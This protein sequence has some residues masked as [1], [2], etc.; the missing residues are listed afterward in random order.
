MREKIM[1]VHAEFR[2]RLQEVGGRLSGLGVIYILTHG[3]KERPDRF[4]LFTDLRPGLGH[5]KLVLIL[6]DYLLELRKQ[7]R[8]DRKERCACEQERRFLL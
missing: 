2:K 5:E 1:D 6:Q 7:I 8:E 3:S 4:E